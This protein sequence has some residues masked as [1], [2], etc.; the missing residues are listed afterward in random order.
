MRLRDALLVKTND[1]AHPYRRRIYAY[2]AGRFIAKALSF[3]IGFF[4]GLYI[5]YLLQ[6]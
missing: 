3:A 5:R 4:G 2:D 6:I 1:P